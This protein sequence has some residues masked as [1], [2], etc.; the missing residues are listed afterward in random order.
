M[1][2][3]WKDQWQ[4]FYKKSFPKLDFLKAVPVIKIA[5][6]EK[7]KM[8]KFYPILISPQIF[9]KNFSPYQTSNQAHILQLSETNTPME[10]FQTK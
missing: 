2:N 5:N 8:K 10:T 4:F 6:S 7:M 1:A 3:S 9:L